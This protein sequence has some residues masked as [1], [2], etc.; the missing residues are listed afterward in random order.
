MT[1]HNA[2]VLCFAE[3]GLFGYFFWIG[4]IVSTVLDLNRT[5]G[6]IEES[7]DHADLLRCA[8]AIRLSLFAF[9]AT[10]WFLS[11]T[12]T[13]TLYLLLGM[14]VALVHLARQANDVDELTGRPP[15]RLTV[16]LQAASIAVIYVMIRLRP[17]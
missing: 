15:W 17:V 4:L 9:L 12:Y 10:A 16:A 13:I 7:G 6:S 8:K 2:F 14:A 5:I 11:R 3:L 1:A